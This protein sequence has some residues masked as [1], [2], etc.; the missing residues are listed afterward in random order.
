MWEK[1][2]EGMRIP[3]TN[4]E[5][6]NLR[7]K[8]I[9]HYVQVQKPSSHP[10]HIAQATLTL[11]PMG[12]TYSYIHAQCDFTLRARWAHRT[13]L[14]WTQ[15]TFFAE[16]LSAR[17]VA[18]ESSETLQNTHKSSKDIGYCRELHSVAHNSRAWAGKGWAHLQIQ[19]KTA[20]SFSTQCFEICV[21][22]QWIKDLYRA[23]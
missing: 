3:T 21:V 6:D 18:A 11:Q 2:R 8:H 4:S 13:G 22:L 5:W 7:G 17:S 15:R 23:G 12:R 20:K 1:Y 19:I 9:H 10:R 16:V 14:C